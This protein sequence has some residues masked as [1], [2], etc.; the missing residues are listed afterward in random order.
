MTNKTEDQR[1]IASLNLSMKTMDEDRRNQEQ[2][3]KITKEDFITLSKQGRSHELR[4]LM[5]TVGHPI[6]NAMFCYY[7]NELDKEVGCE[8]RYQSAALIRSLLDDTWSTFKI[9]LVFHYGDSYQTKKKM[10]LKGMGED[11]ILD[12]SQLSY[13]DY[14]GSK[15]DDIEL[16]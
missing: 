15:D 16:D 11:Y 14:D 4:A 10:L 13:R 8:P 1:A 3:E 12:K 5:N 9:A 7:S 2:L 6:A